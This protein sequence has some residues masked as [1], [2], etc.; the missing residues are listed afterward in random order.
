MNIKSGD[1]ATMA[2]GGGNDDDG[3]DDELFVSSH[4][5]PLRL[6]RLGRARV[7]NT[8]ARGRKTWPEAAGLGQRPQDWARGQLSALTCPTSRCS[9]SS[10]GHGQ[11][12]ANGSNPPC[13]WTALP[14]PS[15]HPSHRTTPPSPSNPRPSPPSS[16]GSSLQAPMQERR[17][18]LGVGV[19]IPA[20]D[21]CA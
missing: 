2:G 19:Q 18:Q 17:R 5:A 7:E 6:Q 9:S 15:N 1:A 21:G 4:R 16:C 20:S 12:P 3:R 8:M 13:H 11:R 14:S 10:P